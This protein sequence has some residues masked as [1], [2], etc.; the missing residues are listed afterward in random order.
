MGHDH[1]TARGCGPQKEPPC[2]QRE[3][4][5]TASASRHTTKFDDRSGQA[6]RPHARKSAGAYRETAN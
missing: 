1:L 2:T 3:R 4:T 5:A 6:P